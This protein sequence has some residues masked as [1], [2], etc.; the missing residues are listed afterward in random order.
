MGDNPNELF[1]L[2]DADDH[3]I[4]TVRRGDAHRNP[5][6]LHRSVQVL[7][8]GGD[9]RLL[10]QRRSRAKDL[11]PGFYC[12]SASG[13]VASGEDYAETAAREV[14]EELGVNLRLAYL[15]KTLVY[16]ESETEM[17]ALFIAHS[18]GPFTFHPT[19]TE[20]GAYF[21]FD[22]VRAS[23]SSGALAMTPALLAALDAVDALERT[24]Q[25]TTMLNTL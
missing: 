2:I 25:L 4:G 3:V 6:L 12:A 11:F 24:G 13:H 15:G 23:R 21:T 9:G 10:L 18:D 20:G 22:E 19:E 14:E 16:S 7:V 5:A 17:T 1:D 8:F